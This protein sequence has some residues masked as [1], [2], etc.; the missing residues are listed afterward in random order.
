MVNLP[1]KYKILWQKCLPILLKC[2]PGDDQHAA[3]TV[4]L[5]ANYSGKLKFDKPV[6]IPV[7]MMHDIGHAAILEQHFKYITGPEKIVNGKLVHMLTG[8]KIARE[9]LKSINYDKKKTAEIVEIIS[10]HEFDQLTG[11]TKKI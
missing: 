10:I 8:A 9:L 6:L 3:E 7:A 4:K 2:R 11:V 1:K 5:M